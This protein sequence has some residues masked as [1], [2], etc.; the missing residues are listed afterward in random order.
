MR[1]WR[2]LPAAPEHVGPIARNMRE[3]DRREVWASHRHTPGEA[4]EHALLGSELAWTCFVHGRP[5]F[6]WGAARQGGLMS[7]AGAP[8]LLGTPAILTVRHEFLR[9]CP[10][11]IARMLERFSRLE[12]FVHA[13]NRVS[14]RWLRW[15]GFTINKT[16]IVFNSEKFFLFW[17]EG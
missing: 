1:I 7:R 4:L 15:C 13:E 6:M 11:Y 16:P 12:N 17:R 10:A 2:I 14:L 9:Q 8:W 3:A 5:A